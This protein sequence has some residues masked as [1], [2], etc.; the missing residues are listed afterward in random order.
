MRTEM[1][2]KAQMLLRAHAVTLT[3]HPRVVFTPQL[4]EERTSRVR[5]KHRLEFILLKSSKTVQKRT[6]RCP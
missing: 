6:G 3:A 4:D 5:L 1:L 2:L